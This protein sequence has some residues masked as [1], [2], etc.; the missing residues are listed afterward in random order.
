MNSKSAPPLTRKAPVSR[1]YSA[2]RTWVAS[3]AFTIATM[4]TG[5]V[6]APILLEVIGKERFGLSRTLTEVFA[7]LGLVGQG[8]TIS[9]VPRL[10]SAAGQGDRGLLDRCLSVGLRLYATVALFL[11]VLGLALAPFLGRLLHI[12]PAFRPELRNAWLICLCGLPLL[13]LSVMKVLVE[14]AHLGYVTNLLMAAQGVLATLLSIVLVLA[15]WGVVGV[16]SAI[17]FTAIGFNLATTIAACRLYP[18]LIRSIKDA[19]PTREDWKSVLTIS[20]PTLVALVSERIGILSDSIVLTRVSGLAAAA[21]LFFTQRLAGIGFGVLNSIALAVWPSLAELYARRELKT[22]CVRLIELTRLVGVL[23]IA[24]FAPMVAYNSLFITRW[25]GAQQDGGRAIAIVAAINGIGLTLLAIYNTALVTT[26]QVS[27]LAKSAAISAVLNITL[28]FFFASWLGPIGPVLGTL[29]A[30][31]C[32]QAW[33]VPLL[34]R[35]IFGVS[36]RSLLWAVTVPLLW[37][38]PYAAFLSWL[39]DSHTPPG[40]FGLLGEMGLASLLFLGFGVRVIFGPEDRQLWNQ[41]LL[42]PLLKKFSK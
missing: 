21:T 30:I 42:Q 14:I 31:L 15:G 7:Y 39:A 37:G 28:S 24:G 17:L 10:A 13:C 33:F 32:V 3:L 16:M 12:E 4:I 35:R 26:G 27:R 38:V 2:M 41:R 22:L 18:N 5:F 19:R 11:I 23:G 6:V 36:C 9:L 34:L 25:V 8:I 40:W 20:G 29:V 1:S